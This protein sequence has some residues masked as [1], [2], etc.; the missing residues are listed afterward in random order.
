MKTCRTFMV[1]IMLICTLSTYAQSVDSLIASCDKHRGKQIA[2]IA[3]Q[4]FAHLYDI[5]FIDERIEIQPDCKTDSVQTLAY[6]WAAEWYYDAQNYSSCI[7]YATQALEL[8]KK[9][10][11]ILEECDSYNILAIAY[12]RKADYRTSLDY[13]KESL[14]YARILKDDS[15]IASALNVLAGICL[16]SKQPAEG[17]KYVLEAIDLCE[18]HKDS[19]CLA[20][21]C[22]MAAEIYHAMGAEEKS[23][24]YSQRS[25]SIDMEMG[26]KDKAAIRLSQMAAA[27]I[28]LKRYDDAETS[29]LHALLELQSAGNRQSWA[30]SCNQLGDI[31]LHKGD[32]EKA[33]EYYHLALAFFKETGDSYNLSHS[34]LGLSKALMAID[35]TEASKHLLEH[36]HIKD[37][38]YNSEMNQG[39]NEYNA[40]YRNEQLSNERDRQRHLKHRILSISIVFSLLLLAIVLALLKRNK[41]VNAGLDIARQELE[42]ARKQQTND[43]RQSANSHI[44]DIFKAEIRKQLQQE[45][46]INL[47]AIADYLHTT[48]ANMSRQ[49]KAETGSSSTALVAEVRINIAKEI[50]EKESN[51]P[52]SDVASACGI[53]VVSYFITLF[54]RHTGVTPKQWKNTKNMAK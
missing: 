36:T 13:V 42:K 2:P 17:E 45:G 48:R 44:A 24:E 34:H 14:S 33:A 35:P 27:Q 9:N 31:Y 15:R 37:T 46:T 4:F 50:L 49:L 25:Y 23:L 12:F 38:L 29:L 16:A 18:K 52:I 41:Y 22:G 10:G 3:E 43:T 28:A 47:Q 7:S 20:A 32:N 8:S 21:R 5:G 53:D 40:L 39:L 54:K 6:Y 11:Y 30:I 1:A 51:T 26:H 19:L